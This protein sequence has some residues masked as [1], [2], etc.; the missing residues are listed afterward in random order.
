MATLNQGILGGVSGKVGP[1]VGT[2]WKGKAVI[3]SKAL[4]IHDPK[5]QAQL[6]ERAR[7]A[8]LMHFIARV[9]GF[10]KMG[11]K[12][13]AVDMTEADYALKANHTNGVTGTYP[14]FS[15]NYQGFVLAKGNVDLPYNPS[16]SNDGSDLTFQWTDNSG[17]GN[18]KAEDQAMVLVFNTAKNQA[19]Y[20]LEAAVRS[21]RTYS[22]ALPSAWTGDTVEVYMAFRR[23]DTSEASDSVY[24]GS[25]TL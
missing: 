9:Y 5:T 16:A 10:I 12:S 14:N 13:L 15:I 18:A 19:V 8:L 17:V 4:S 2:S 20:N 11:F 21:D 7:F 6:E 1:V 3:R 25:I 24:L 22:M 23:Q